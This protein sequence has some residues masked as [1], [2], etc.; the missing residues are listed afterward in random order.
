MSTKKKKRIRKTSQITVLNDGVIVNSMESNSAKDAPSINA[1]N[2]SFLNKNT[3]G[4]ISGNLVLTNNKTIKGNTLA[5]RSLTILCVYSDNN[6]LV[7]SPELSMKIR[8]ATVPIW[9]NGSV[10]KKL[11][12]EGDAALGDTLPVGS[13]IYVDN[14]DELPAGYEKIDII[15]PKQLLINNDFQ[16][17]QRG[18]SEYIIENNKSSYTLDMWKVYAESNSSSKLTK[19]MNGIK[20]ETDG[21]QLF[22]V[23]NDTYKVNTISIKIN[24]LRGNLS[25]KIYNDNDGWHNGIESLKVGVNNFTIREETPYKRIGILANGECT[26]EIEYIDLF[27]G[28]IAYP[29][30][31]EDYA[32]TLM[33]CQQYIFSYPKDVVFNSTS[34]CWQ[35]KPRDTIICDFQLPT[36]M[37]GLPTF[38]YSALGVLSR[39]NAKLYN[40]FNMVVFNL[41]RNSIDIQLRRDEAYDVVNDEWYSVITTNLIISCEPL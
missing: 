35:L 8:S 12:V 7:G 22:Q 26:V 40:V 34:L 13:V 32:T 9:E 41:R 4:T 6:V 24:V 3:G 38:T 14:D 1:V 37:K 17:N 23:F 29:H 36:T 18:Q 30:V 27:E 33:K 19:L 10:K 5:G 25:M 15:P 20:L 16:C 21:G 28:D 2:R 39:N 11:L 31:K